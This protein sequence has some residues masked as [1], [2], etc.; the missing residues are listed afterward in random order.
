MPRRKKKVLSPEEQEAAFE[1][2][3]SVEDGEYALMVELKNMAQRMSLNNPES[4]RLAEDLTIKVEA[5]MDTFKNIGKVFKV[6]GCKKFKKAINQQNMRTA[7]FGGKLNSYNFRVQKERRPVHH[8]RPAPQV[9]D[10]GS[11]HYR[12][13]YEERLH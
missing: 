2:W 4:F 11:Q 12:K 5:F 7:F 8:R 10:K 1:E 9:R 6:K 13:R 3:K